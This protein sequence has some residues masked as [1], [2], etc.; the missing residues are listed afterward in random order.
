MERQRSSTA[1]FPRIAIATCAPVAGVEKDDL[2]LIAALRRRGVD[3]TH[4]I[5]DD[6]AVAWSSFDLVVVRSTWDYPDRLSAFLAWAGRLPRVL[7]SLPIL[8]W[9]TDKRYLNDLA[10]AGLPV[11]PTRFLQP[12]DGLELPPPPFVIKP[13]VSCGAKDTARYQEGDETRAREHVG[14]LQALG[15]VVMLQPYLADIDEQGEVALMFIGGAYSHSIRRGALLNHPETP[16]DD[17][18]RPLNVRAYEATDDER[19]LAD[20]VMAC[21]PGGPAGLLYGR[22]DLVPGPNGELRILEVELTEPSLFLEYSNEGVERLAESV[23]TA[24][25]NRANE[26]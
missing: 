2:A 1:P 26:L 10:R 6:P 23:V 5:W 12:N 9:N 21:V 20:Q 22:V 16:G 24:V 18:P 13:A 14:R 15:R 25:A 17:R 3:A 11:I 7:N 19:Y 4:A 8:R